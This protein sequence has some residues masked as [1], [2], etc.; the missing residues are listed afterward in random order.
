M[1]DR[2]MDSTKNKRYCEIILV[3]PL[4]RTADVY[5]TYPLNDCP[6]KEWNDIDPKK[7]AQENNSLMAIKNGPRYFEMDDVF[8]KQDQKPV[9]KNFKGIDMIK[10]ATLP[11][12]FYISLKPY[13]IHSVDRKAKFTYYKN[14]IVYVLKDPDGNQYM[15][16]SATSKD[17]SDLSQMIQLPSSWN[18]NVFTLSK[19][20][21]VDTM[22]KNA[23]VIQDNLGNSYTKID[24]QMQF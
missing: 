16:Q 21:I 1:I 15:M 10:R 6:E 19:D 24:S 5:N 3:Y 4:Q 7:I 14:S 11:I 13:Q 12:S 9:M 17:L 18:L 8:Q 2:W 23:L 20:F 22:D